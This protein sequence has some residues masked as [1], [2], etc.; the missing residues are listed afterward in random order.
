MVFYKY[1]KSKA[2]SNYDVLPDPRGPLAFIIPPTTIESVLRVRGRMHGESCTCT[3]NNTG[4]VKE[5]HRHSHGII[6][7]WSCG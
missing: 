7:V 4:V 2:E 6:W 1:L 3:R 5:Y